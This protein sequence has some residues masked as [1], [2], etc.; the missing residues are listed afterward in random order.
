MHAAAE[1]ESAPVVGEVAVAVAEAGDLLNEQVD[2]FGWFVA[3]ATGG[4]EGEDLV[5][6]VV[7]GVREPGELGDVGLRGVLEEHDEP[8]FRVVEAVGGVD[9]GEELAGEPDGGDV[10]VGV[11]GGEPV[12]EAFPAPLVEV[13]PSA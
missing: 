2:G 12:A 7:D 4:V 3:G 8:S 9:L 10:A 6:P 11:A 1:E 5:A 13:G